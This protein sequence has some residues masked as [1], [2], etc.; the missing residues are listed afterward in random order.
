MKLAI[1]F[2]LLF[3]LLI[4]YRLRHASFAHL[5]GKRI[6]SRKR[7]LR[8]ARRFK[9]MR[10]A[11]CDFCL[12]DA[13]S[14]YHN[15][16]VTKTTKNNYVRYYKRTKQYLCIDCTEAVRE[17][18]YKPYYAQELDTIIDKDEIIAEFVENIP[19]WDQTDSR[20]FTP[21]EIDTK[22]DI[23]DETTKE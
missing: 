8:K 3:C 18:V 16:F 4:S 5:F 6:M 19:E 11:I 2:G 21:K 7:K 1:M 14:S 22:I 20:W 10:C 15:G 13:Q 12:G 17:N 23:D 9:D